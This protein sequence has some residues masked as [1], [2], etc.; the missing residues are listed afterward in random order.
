M[1][2]RFPEST[3]F[4]L[5]TSCPTFYPALAA[6]PSEW[7]I[8]WGIVPLPTPEPFFY[9][10]FFSTGK[11]AQRVKKGRERVITNWFPLCCLEQVWERSCVAVCPLPLEQPLCSKK[12]LGAWW[13]VEDKDGKPRMSHMRQLCSAH[14]RATMQSPNCRVIMFYT[15]C[16]HLTSR[17]RWDECCVPA[18]QSPSPDSSHHSST[19]EAW[20]CSSSWS[21]FY[22]CGCHSP[23]NTEGAEA[24]RLLCSPFVVH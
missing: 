7:R 16:V 20:N 21:G 10:L 4:L 9:A 12:H 2:C 18:H 1:A 23:Q 24:G 8:R 5:F 15:V 11:P 6:N 19:I 13:R 14:R 3:G 17:A 22:C